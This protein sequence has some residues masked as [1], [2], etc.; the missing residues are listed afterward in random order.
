M[1]APVVLRFRTYGVQLNPVSR[2]YADAMLALPALQEW[3]AAAV[4]GDRSRSPHSSRSPCEDLPR[5]RLGARRA[6]RA[7]RSRTTTT[8]WSAATPK[9]MVRLGFRPVG[10]DFPVFLHPQT[11]EE[12]ALARTERKTGR[13]YKG[14]AV[15]RRAGRHAG[16]G[17]GAPRP[18]HQRDRAR[19]PRQAHRPLRR[20]AGPEARASCVTSALPSSKIRC[21][22]CAWRASPPASPSRSRRRRWR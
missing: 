13:G 21:A 11:H 2:E 17:P 10:K 12:Y 5:R 7:C 3:V 16:A 4:R 19:R 8:S 15:S 6:A 14:F 1:Y 20:R 22:S 9:Q 18:H